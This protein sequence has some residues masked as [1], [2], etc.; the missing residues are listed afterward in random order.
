MTQEQYIINMIGVCLISSI[1]GV[2]FKWYAGPR[3]IEAIVLATIYLIYVTHASMRVEPSTLDTY[4]C[5]TFIYCF[6]IFPSIEH[7]AFDE[8][9]V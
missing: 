4:L 7:M 8:D 3:P 6:I 2:F 5:S 9:E 1:Y